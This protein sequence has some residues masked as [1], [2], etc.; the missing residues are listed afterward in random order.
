MKKF[1]ITI[2]FLSISLTTFGQ[3]TPSYIVKK[4][5]AASEYI[6]AEM[7]LDENQQKNI[8]TILS[9][10]YDSNRKDIR[11]KNLSNEEKQKIYKASFT[12]TKQYLSE[13]FTMKEVNMI[14]RLH[15]DWQKKNKK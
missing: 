14:N 10:K 12:K 8:Y 11:G 9:E 5:T 4:A 7:N 6:A 3:K 13:K 2:L 15:R 1:I